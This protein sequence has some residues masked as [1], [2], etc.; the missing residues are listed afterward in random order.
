MTDMPIRAMI[1]NVA[2]LV[3]A[4]VLVL[5]LYALGAGGFSAVGFIILLNIQYVRRKPTEK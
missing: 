4:A 1:E 5:G 2:T 3:I